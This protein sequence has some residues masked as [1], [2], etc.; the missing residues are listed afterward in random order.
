MKILNLMQG[1]P[2]WMEIRQEKIT[3]T[4]CA[5]ILGKSRYKSARMVWM[6]KIGG[7]KKPF[8][9]AA[10]ER[11]ILLE[12]IAR[13][14]FEEKFDAPF[15]PCVGISSDRE[16][17]MASLDGYNQEKHHILEIKCS[18]ESVFRRAQEGDVSEDYIWQ[19]YHQ[20]AVFDEAMEATLAFYFEGERGIETVEIKI[21]RDEENIEEL[22]QKEKKFFYE[23]ILQFK[24][25]EMTS[26]D[27]Q[28]KDDFEWMESSE[29][30]REA[31][32]AL[33]QAEKR[34]ESLREALISMSNGNSC[35]GGGVQLT[36]Y[37][38]RGTVDYSKIPELSSV[39]LNRYR[40]ESSESWR[41]SIL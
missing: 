17:Q 20:L 24:E 33:Q 34:E 39:D 14:Y 1:S 21:S 40:K 30:W 8:K 25:P 26:M 18:G 22:I 12:P 23:N 15:S 2:E 19:C 31:K 36:K 41:I 35:R 6:D 32:I 5:P 9:N 37:I 27:V 10:M 29:R 7:S 28:V 11:G 3:A 38:R 4:D 16:W 13:R